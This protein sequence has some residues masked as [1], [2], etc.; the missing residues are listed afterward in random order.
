M[1][2]RKKGKLATLDRALLE[3]LSLLNNPFFGE[4]SDA[5]FCIPV[6]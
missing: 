1:A 5:I 2:I 3:L 6:I 4:A